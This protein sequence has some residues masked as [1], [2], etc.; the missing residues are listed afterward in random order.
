MRIKL[1]NYL[2]RYIEKAVTKD[3][4]RKMVLVSG[5][6]QS[7]KT[8][9]AKHLCEAAGSDIEKRYLNWDAAEDREKILLERFPAGAGYLVLDE[10]HKY[11]RWRQVVKGL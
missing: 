6:R 7:G 2:P 8:T 3:L 1:H 9:M 4:K 11:S 10:I 5:P